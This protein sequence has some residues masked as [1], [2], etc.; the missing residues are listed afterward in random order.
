MDNTPTYQVAA[1]NSEVKGTITFFARDNGYYGQIILT[2]FPEGYVITSTLVTPPIVEAN[3]ETLK[4]EALK[5]GQEYLDTLKTDTVDFGT[6]KIVSSADE[7]ATRF[8]ES[9]ED[10]PTDFSALNKILSI[11]ALKTSL[12]ELIIT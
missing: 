1:D 11:L 2:N 9:F 8:I 12:S 3:Y 5:L 7:S 6:L 4:V 10:N